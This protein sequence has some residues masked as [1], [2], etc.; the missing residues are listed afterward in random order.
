MHTHDH[1]AQN[2]S[3]IIC[4]GVANA[5]NNTAI[6][7]TFNCDNSNVN[8][9]KTRIMTSITNWFFQIWTHD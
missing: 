8:N 5:M 6:I 9:M 4:I 2:V 3:K 1:Q 7:E